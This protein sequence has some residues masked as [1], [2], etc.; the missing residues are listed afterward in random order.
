MMRRSKLGLALLTIGGL[1]LT[2]CRRKEGCM[3]QVATNYCS[4]C[5]RHKGEVCEYDYTIAFWFDTTFARYLAQ[6]EVDTLY[7]RISDPDPQ[8]GSSQ[9][10]WNSFYLRSEAFLTEPTC[11][12]SRVKKFRFHYRLG[13]MPDVCGGGGGFLGGG[14]SRCWRLTYSAYYPGKGVIRDGSITIGPGATGCEKIRF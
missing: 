14:G 11:E 12:D 2:A 8:S 4:D 5:N 6:L 9:E 3:E 13:D 10:L 7:L 1:L